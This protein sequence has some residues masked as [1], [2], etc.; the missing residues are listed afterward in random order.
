VETPTA[1]K[2]TE[3]D[4]LPYLLQS[5]RICLRTSYHWF[6][7]VLDIKEE[8]SVEVVTALLF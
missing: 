7:V 8:E 1:P 5:E 2:K 3:L 6:N 4:P